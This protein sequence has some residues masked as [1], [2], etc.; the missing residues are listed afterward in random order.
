[1]RRRRVELH[2][3]RGAQEGE[4]REAGAETR[5][6]AGGKDV[7]RAD[8]VIAEHL[9]RAC[10]HEERAVVVES[11]EHGPGI[12]EH[13][14]QVFRRDAVAERDR[15]VELVA[16]GAG[17]R[18]ERGAGNRGGGW[19]QIGET[20]CEG[21][22]DRSRK[23]LVHRHEDRAG[24]SIVLG[25]GHEIRRHQLGVRARVGEHHELGG[26]GQHVD[27]D[28][29]V[30]ELLRRAHPLVA[31]AHNQVAAL[32]RLGA[33]GERRN[34]LRAAHADDAVRSRERGRREHEVARVRTRD[35]DPAHSRHPRRDHAHQHRGRQGIAPSRRVA[36][37]RR[38]GEK[39]VPHPTAFDLDAGIAEALPLRARKAPNPLRGPGEA[40]PRAG[41]NACEGRVE[42]V[43][44]VD[45]GSGRSEVAER[46]RVR[47][48]RA[49]PLPAYV[50][51]DFRRP[52]HHRLVGSNV[53]PRRHLSRGHHGE[54]IHARGSVFAS[55]PRREKARLRRSS[56]SLTDASETPEAQSRVIVK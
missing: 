12:F 37:G 3:G 42:G 51:D 28:I 40:F 39:A 44:V 50:F 16:E 14:L 30:D 11:G 38:D 20:A 35:L 47:Q 29:A 48:Q 9:R 18:A 7:V 22:L 54:E 13:H 26:P 56:A 5:A 8:S 19:W 33:V 49:I 34:R 23:R 53:G 24:V 52:C 21:C 36:A 31:G 15:L 25:L 45:P 2:P 46:V 32:D 27:A 55:P 17:A 1:M 6:P 4:H 10:S 43:L 41:G